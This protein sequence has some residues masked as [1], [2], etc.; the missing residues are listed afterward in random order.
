MEINEAKQIKA[1]DKLVIDSISGKIE[2]VIEKNDGEQIWINGQ[3]ESLENAQAKLDSG[4]IEI[5]RNGQS[6]IQE[7]VMNQVAELELEL[8]NIEL[9]A[10]NRGNNYR[11]Y[12]KYYGKDAGMI[13]IE[14]DGSIS[15]DGVKRSC[16]SDIKAVV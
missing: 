6:N 11:V 4:Q 13:K 9:N 1:G 8:D 3:S 10:W 15:I 2:M 14:Q 7:R 16:Y 5:I 12:I